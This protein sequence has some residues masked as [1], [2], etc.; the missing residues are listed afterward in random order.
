M[1]RRSLAI[2]LALAAAPALAATAVPAQERILVNRDRDGLALQGHDPVAYFVDRKPVKGDAR[3]RAV[4]RGAV[5]HFASREHLEMFE[6]EPQKYEPAFGGYCGYAASINRLSPISPEFWEIID[7]RLVLQH[8]QKAWDAWHEDRAGNLRKADANWPGLVERNGST[9][10]LLVNTDRD[11]VAIRGHDPVAYFA[12]QRAVKGDPRHEAVYD[13]ARYWFKSHENRV[14][15]ENDPVRYAPAYGGY[16]AYAASIDKVSP[17]DPEIFQITDGRLMLQHT[18]K[19]YELFNADTAGSVRR[20]DANWPDLVER[21]GRREGG[22][23]L[24][25]RLWQL[26]P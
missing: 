14:T 22:L 24:G 15:F 21:H 5:Y 12:E 9:A 18:R 20:A 13:G 17:I 1:N 4:Q 25:Q 2:V 19:A 8:N 7:G 26:I 23:T 10:A 6:R 3:F 16:C 11:G